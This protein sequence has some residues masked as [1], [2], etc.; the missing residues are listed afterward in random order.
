MHMLVDL[1]ATLHLRAR[2]GALVAVGALS[3]AT[4]HRVSR[5]RER[6]RRHH[7]Q[8]R[9]QRLHLRV[10]P[11]KCA[12]LPQRNS[13]CSALPL[14]FEPTSSPYRKAVLDTRSEAVY[15]PCWEHVTSIRVHLCE[16]RW[17]DRWFG[18]WAEQLQAC[19]RWTIGQSQAA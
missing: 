2:V 19:W 12:R 17:I 4:R 9:H 10:T 11:N 5:T 14:S 7:R 8:R 6:G 13:S 1:S 16:Q 15:G 3:V 18:A